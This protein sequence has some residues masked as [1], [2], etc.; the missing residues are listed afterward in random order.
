MLAPGSVLL[1]TQR[2]G[3]GEEAGALLFARPRHVL[4]AHRPSEVASLL[5]ALAAEARRGRYVAGYLAYEAAYALDRTGFPDPPAPAGPLAWFGVYDAPERL[6]PA[7][8]ETRLA[9]AA[10]ATVS[11]P[12]LAWDRATYRTRVEAVRRHIREG[13]VYQINLTAPL[14]FRF[15]GDPLGLYRRLR[16]AQRVAYGAVVRTETAWILSLS[17]EL[18]VRRDGDRL[19]ARPMKGTARRGPDVAAD[20][21]V[22]RSLAASA[23]D[24]AENL[25]IVDL[26]R[27]DLAVVAEPGSVRVPALFTVE[28][29]ETL[30]QMTST[31]TARA[32][33]GV[34][35]ADVLR[36]L[37]PCGSVTGAPKRRAMQLIRHLEPGP[38]GVYC[39]AIGV[40]RPGGD[41][42]FSVPIRTVELIGAEGRMGVG[43]GIVWDS[44]P[45]A[46]YAECLLKGRFLTSAP[47]GFRLLETMRTE[48]GTVALLE[49]HL[50]RLR[51][52]AAYFGFWLDEEVVRTVV[53]ERASAGPH[54]LRLT[55]GVDGDVQAEVGPLETDPLRTA[56][57][58]PEPVPEDDPFLRHKTTHRPVYARALAWARSQGADEALLRTADGRLTEGTRTNVW[59]E[60]DGRL[61]TPSLERGGVPGVYR[62]HLLRTDPRAAE[63]PLRV[64]DLGRADRVLLS[65]A[66]RGLVP[67]VLLEPV[68]A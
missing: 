1:D 46:E 60:R 10:P 32:R 33:P 9:A 31:V 61:L 21:A 5:E 4:V 63:A 42:V 59:I 48:G 67:V 28:R 37:F 54:R 25:M 39:G 43:S 56:V 68:H 58:Y 38:R 45:D 16:H 17:P 52:A 44:D 36:A 3:P 51:A 8:L 55:V 26:L 47:P 65:N 11:P 53:R 24:R 7:D 34:T 57:L 35:V 49:E 23:K 50:A 19:T 15:A 41:F 40:V 62:A 22:A 13:D 18:F 66:V 30:W 6:A 14:R 64:E 27:N 2:P 29:Y 20:E 12:R